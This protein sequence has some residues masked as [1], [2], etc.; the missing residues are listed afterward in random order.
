MRRRRDKKAVINDKLVELFR[1]A[2][3]ARKAYKKRHLPVDEIQRL[4]TIVYSFH[5]A[6]NHMP[7][8]GVRNDPLRAGVGGEAGALR[9]ALLAE[10]K[11][12]LMGWRRLAAC[13][14]WALHGNLKH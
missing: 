6:I 4:A 1:D 9:A 5:K 8:H 12:H 14:E 11:R 3:A 7:W 13:P 10:I 2:L